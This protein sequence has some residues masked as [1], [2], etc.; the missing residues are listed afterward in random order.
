ME[1]D[2]TGYE[3]ERRNLERNFKGKTDKIKRQYELFWQQ[4][5]AKADVDAYLNAVADHDYPKLPKWISKV[6]PFTHWKGPCFAESDRALLIGNRASF[7]TVQYDKP[8]QAGMSM[9]HLLCIPKTG[10]FNGVGLDSGSVS[11]IDHMVQLFKSAWTDAETRRGVLCHQRE[12]IERRNQE[13]PDEE[14]H[15]TAME[16]YGELEDMIDDLGPDD[17]HFGLHLWPDHSV[18]HLHL[19]V[20]AAPWACRQYSTSHH[21]KKTK[22]AFEVRDYI[23]SVANA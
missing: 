19:H 23:K 8:E 13:N 3:S 16:H 2:H 18:G 9:I 10:I 1:G 7:D 20:I 4:A 22:D 12:A 21:D 6:T 14:A 17:F 15:A 11:I 5:T